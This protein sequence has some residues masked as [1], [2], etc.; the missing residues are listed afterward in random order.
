[1]MLGCVSKGARLS[2]LA[3]PEKTLGLC[4]CCGDVVQAV[5]RGGKDGQSQVV[6]S[7]ARQDSRGRLSP[8]ESGY[9][10]CFRLF[11]TRLPAFEPSFA[12]SLTIWRNA[13]TSALSG[14]WRG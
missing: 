9:F 5:D 4:T 1:M 12:A 3:Q 8:R 14:R 2:S 13:R 6:Q 7:F 11:L 10:W